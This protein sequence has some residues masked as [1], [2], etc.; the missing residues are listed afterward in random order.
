MDKT[1][2]KNECVKDSWEMLFDDFQRKCVDKI[3]E[4]NLVRRLK[5]IFRI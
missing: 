3:I 1:L 5:L 4:R 2:D